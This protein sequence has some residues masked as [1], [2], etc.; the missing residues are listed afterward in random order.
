MSHSTTLISE[1]AARVKAKYGDPENYRELWL[2]EAKAW[3]KELEAEGLTKTVEQ[4]DRAI[5]F[6]EK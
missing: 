2:E 5:R 6:I 3:R 1:I 4:L